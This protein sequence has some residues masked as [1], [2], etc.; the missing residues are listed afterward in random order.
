MEEK[1][2]LREIIKEA[3]H[4]DNITC[5]LCKALDKE[6]VCDEVGTP[7]H[8]CRIAVA[9]ILLDAI[10]NEFIERP[11]FEDGE[12]VQFG[13]RF[14]SPFDSD[15]YE[16][17]AEIAVNSEGRYSLRIADNCMWYAYE[18]GGRVK[19]PESKV[20]EADGKPIKV[21]DTVWH[22]ANGTEY[23]VDRIN[24]DEYQCVVL[25]RERYGVTINTNV[26]AEL[27]THEQ[28]D[29]L[30]RIEEDAA[31]HSSLYCE[32]YGIKTHINGVYCPEK[33][34]A[35]DLLARQRK[36]LERDR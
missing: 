22:V 19:R 7:E 16:T 36:V 18:L 3:G 9:E 35:I 28:P 17:V 10:Y 24:T 14:V 6:C 32:K 34:M 4:S 31:M 1:K 29:S 12:P 26:D 13:D 20:L 2:T 23:V 5:A 8:G 25:R 30:E 21:G 11:R 33:A 27:I 15:N